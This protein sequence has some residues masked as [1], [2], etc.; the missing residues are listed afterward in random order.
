MAEVAGV[1]R[2]VRTALPRTGAPATLDALELLL[3]D[4]VEVAGS[5]ARMGHRGFNGFMERLV[6]AH[7]ED[8]SRTIGAIARPGHAQAAQ[9]RFAWQ[10]ARRLGVDYMYP[11]V[12]IREGGDAMVQMVPGT[13]SSRAGVNTV[14]DLDHAIRRWYEQSRPEMGPAR[15]AEQA[16]I[17]RELARVIDNIGANHD[18]GT[19]NVMA[20]PVAGGVHMI[21][22]GWMGG[23]ERLRVTRPMLSGQFGGGS[24]GALELHPRTVQ[25]VHDNLS[26]EVLRELHADLVADLARWRPTA[27]TTLQQRTL[28]GALRRSLSRP[29]YLDGMLARREHILA[30]GRIEHAGNGYNLQTPIAIGGTLLRAYP[31]HA[32]VAGTLAIG[33]AATGAALLHERR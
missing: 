17:D 16:R 25:I 19:G 11:A 3:R 22:F 2:A 23:G 20:D 10:L 9:E 4:G 7:P 6:L 15:I 18:R 8:A 21:D 32:A 5:R 31:R 33:G 14:D 13:I 29:G 26:P 30:T 12:A 28:Q 24:A 1:A 27:E